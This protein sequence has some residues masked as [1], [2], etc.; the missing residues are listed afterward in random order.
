MV[1][2][3][4][5][6]PECP[7]RNLSEQGREPTTNSTHVWRYVDVRILMQITLVGVACHC[8]ILEQASNIKQR[9]VET[10]TAI[11]MYTD[12]DKDKVIN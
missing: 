1:L 3:E 12:I 8:P 2:R 6:K 7:E 4:R 11:F 10:V 9:W 5:G